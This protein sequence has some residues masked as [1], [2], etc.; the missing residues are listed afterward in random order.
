M[1]RFATDYVH[2]KTG[3]TFSSSHEV[4][5]VL[6]SIQTD[7]EELVNRPDYRPE[8]QETI[9][10]INISNLTR[11]FLETT[12]N[13][14]QT[15]ISSLANNSDVDRVEH[16]L[17]KLEG[18]IRNLFDQNTRLNKLPKENIE[19][20]LR[21][22]KKKIK[23]ILWQSPAEELLD[24]LKT[25]E[26]K[27]YDTIEKQTEA[28]E[29]LLKNTTDENKSTHG[30]FRSAAAEIQDILREAV[31]DSE[32]VVSDIKNHLYIETTQVVEILNTTALNISETSKV[33]E[34]EVKQAKNVDEKLETFKIF[35]ATLLSTVRNAVDRIVKF[36]P[37]W[38]SM[39]LGIMFIPGPVLI[40]IW[41]G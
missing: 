29:K 21:E 34:Q 31:K 11:D 3:I 33:A 4:T 35:T 38:A 39:T 36:H 41:W 14:F 1:L 22:A 26:D 12:E 10:N 19:T 20:K 7:L 6:E 23:K 27:I 17:V 16:E 18:S 37:I 2:E 30:F 24:I 13:K 40:C 32:M 25:T 28:L 9:K 15:I 8:V 5:D